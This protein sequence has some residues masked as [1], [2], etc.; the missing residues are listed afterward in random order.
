ML[1]N[2]DINNPFLFDEITD[3]NI[4]VSFDE[5]SANTGD[6]VCITSLYEELIR[7][8]GSYE[9][10]KFIYEFAN[11]AIIDGKYTKNYPIQSTPYLDFTIYLEQTIIDE[12][13]LSP[14][15]TK[16]VPGEKYYVGDTVYY[17]ID[18]SDEHIKTYILKK[19]DQTETFEIPF[20]VYEANSGDSN[21]FESNG[22]YY[23]KT[24]CYRGYYSKKTKLTYFDTLNN[25]GT[26]R[27]EHWKEDITNNISPD[28]QHEGIIGKTASLLENIMRKRT[29]MDA[30]GT[31]LPFILHYDN[32]IEGGVIIG[33]E[34]NTGVTETFYM[35]GNMNV[36]YH[37]DSGKVVSDV[38]DSV[39]FYKSDSAPEMGV[40]FTEID[41][42][43]II[44][45]NK[46]AYTNE[47]NITSIAGCDMIQFVYYSNATLVKRLN[48]WVRKEKTG[49][50]YVETRPIVIQTS[51]FDIEVKHSGTTTLTLTY[52]DVNSNAQNEI[53][54]SNADI[55]NS[56]KTDTN[57][58]NVSVDK[59][60]LG[61]D[62]FLNTKVFKD[63]STMAL[64]DI[65]VDLDVN[66]ERGIAESFQKH[67]MLGEICTLQDLENYKNG[68]YLE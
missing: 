9:N 39:T 54:Y 42:P 5:E 63:E 45:S 41:K 22:K 50:K 56:L 44:T 46:E 14:Y 33:R 10:A 27:L 6:V 48:T 28:I 12:G 30:S 68:K 53:D 37:F 60:Q 25:D 36:N 55:I 38:L 57:Y 23:R 58:S 61:D 40:S 17:S 3:N 26:L 31:T 18:G 19:G 1:Y 34:L 64:Q 49:V 51:D 8:F 24:A 20:S 52:I 47:N 29:D 2:K 65:T 7:R 15:A 66:I 4:G 11:S 13:L 43:I 32:I 21:Y 59:S 35:C 16:W 62:Y 67:N